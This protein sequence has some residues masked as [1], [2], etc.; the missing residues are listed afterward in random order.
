MSILG[1]FALLV[2]QDRVAEMAGELESLSNG[3]PLAPTVLGEPYAL[4][5]AASGRAA[6]ARAAAGR[7]ARSAGTSSGC[8]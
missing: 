5:L 1:R 6:E 8:S 3:I 2:M 7:R 4:A